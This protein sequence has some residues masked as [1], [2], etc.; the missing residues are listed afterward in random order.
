M[1]EPRT[2]QEALVYFGD[3]ERAFQFAVAL[4]WPV[5]RIDVA[6][7]GCGIPDILKGQIFDP[8]F[9]TKGVG[10]GSGLGLSTARSIVKAH[11]GFITFT[12]AEGSGTTF[13]VFLPA[14]SAGLDR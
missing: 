4:R 5:I 3:K 2:L 1:N 7:T 13:S 14:A 11:R 6:D 9:T 10:R 8:F 12:S